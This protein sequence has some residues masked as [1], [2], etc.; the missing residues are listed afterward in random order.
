MF[1]FQESFLFSDFSDIGRLWKGYE[2]EVKGPWGN[3][4][5][6]KIY[7]MGDLA[8]WKYHKSVKEGKDPSKLNYLKCGMLRVLS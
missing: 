8:F 5:L 1:L 4:K 6:Q 2:K 7:I 3:I